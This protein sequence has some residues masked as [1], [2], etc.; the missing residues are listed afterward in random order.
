MSKEQVTGSSRAAD[1]YVPNIFPTD[2]RAPGKI[3]VITVEKAERRPLLSLALARVP[4]FHCFFPSAAGVARFQSSP[5]FSF[6]FSHL[7]L[8]GFVSLSTRLGHH[9]EGV[10]VG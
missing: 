7:S 4:P 3:R 8:R 2:A 5:S 6:L 1:Y 10:K 9:G